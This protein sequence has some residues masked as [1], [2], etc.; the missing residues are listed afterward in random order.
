MQKYLGT[1]KATT[2][3]KFYTNILNLLK[4]FEEI[5]FKN[6]LSEFKHFLAKCVS[7]NSYDK[8]MSSTRKNKPG[9]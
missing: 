6:F 9:P 3:Q 1:D 2:L 4:F 8:Q 5:Y 7:Y